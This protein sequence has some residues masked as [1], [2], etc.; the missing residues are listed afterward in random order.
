[1]PRPS[2]P[3]VSPVP[4]PV[5]SA[6]T[7][8]TFTYGSEPSSTYAGPNDSVKIFYASFSP[9][10][11]QSGTLV[12]ISTI[13]TTNV[14]RITVGYGGYATQLALTSPGQWQAAF[15]FIPGDVPVGTKGLTLTLTAYRVDGVSTNISIPVTLVPW[16]VVARPLPNFR[17]GRYLRPS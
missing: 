7:D 13:T 16:W 10:Q 17:L 11:L 14:N 1:M 15:N 8:Q 5:P 2:L 9:T 6:Q 4:S 3:S 12:Q